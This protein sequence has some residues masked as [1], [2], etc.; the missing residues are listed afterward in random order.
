MDKTIVIWLVLANVVALFVLH[1][2]LHAMG[3][4]VPLQDAVDSVFE[5]V[6]AG[7]AAYKPCGLLNTSAFILTSTRVVWPDGVRPGAGEAPGG[8]A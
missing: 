7:H 5:A 2:R 8:R 3:W 1:Q 4:D 6:G